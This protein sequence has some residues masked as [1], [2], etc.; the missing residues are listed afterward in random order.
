MSI[1]PQHPQHPQPSPAGPHRS[2]PLPQFQPSHGQAYGYPA[3]GS[4]PAGP[5]Y[6]VPAGLAHIGARF[7]ARVLD[8]IF[9]Y[10]GYFA[11]AIPVMM[12]IDA[13]G[14]APAVALLIAWLAISFVLYFALPVWKF[15]STLGKRICGIR[16]VR[17]ETAA[18]VGFWRAAGREAFW[19]VAVFVPVLGFLNPLWCCWDRPYQQC[20]HDKVADTMA[21]VR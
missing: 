5:A 3:P 16:V 9:W 7:G 6:G 14:G 2:A 19:L 4:V 18:P 11:L 1:P 15:G 13:D 10:I 8:V 21:V 17:R 12:W 20:L